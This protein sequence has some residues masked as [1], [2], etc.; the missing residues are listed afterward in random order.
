M[1]QEE[2]ILKEFG[3]RLKK[4][5]ES[6]EWTQIDLAFRLKSSVSHVSKLENGHVEPGLLMLNRLAKILECE[7]IDLTV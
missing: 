3:A 2:R 1:K 6:K 5:R 4:L 7:L